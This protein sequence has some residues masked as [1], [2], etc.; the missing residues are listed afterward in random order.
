MSSFFSLSSDRERKKHGDDDDVGLLLLLLPTN[1]RT[2]GKRDD[3]IQKS[4]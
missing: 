3:A 1:E 4:L 2:N